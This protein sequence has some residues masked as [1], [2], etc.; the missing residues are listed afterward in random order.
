MFIVCCPN[1]QNVL[2]GGTVSTVA[3]N[4]QDIAEKVLHVIT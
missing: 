4:A 2:M 1:D 3:D